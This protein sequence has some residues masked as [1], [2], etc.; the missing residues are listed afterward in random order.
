MKQQMKR[1]WIF[2]ILDDI[3]QFLRE[4]EFNEMAEDVE[5]LLSKYADALQYEDAPPQAEKVVAQPSAR[6]YKF[7]DTSGRG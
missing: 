6:M 2:P 5:R 7:P 1:D 3:S 4:T